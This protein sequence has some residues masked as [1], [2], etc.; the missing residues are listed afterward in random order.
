MNTLA[1]HIIDANLDTLDWANTQNIQVSKDIFSQNVASGS[2]CLAH[3]VH[4]ATVN[5]LAEFMITESQKRGLRRKYINLR[6]FEPPRLT[7]T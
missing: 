4:Q 6:T 2:L 1:Y 3:D 7:K 5:S